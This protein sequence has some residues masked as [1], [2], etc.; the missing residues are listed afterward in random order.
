[1]IE[2]EF[3]FSS[4]G[5]FHESS[6]QQR[7]DDSSI[8][9]LVNQNRS[10]TVLCDNIQVNIVSVRL[11]QSGLLSKHDERVFSNLKTCQQTIHYLH[12]LHAFLSMT[13]SMIIFYFSSL[14][15]FCSSFDR[16]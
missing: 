5:K 10:E 6:D 14:S 4:D 3:V 13:N 16:K 11:I 2:N 12:G 15:S 7:Q 8:S 1:M 9:I